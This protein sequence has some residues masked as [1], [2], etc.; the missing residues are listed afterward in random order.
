[1]DTRFGHPDDWGLSPERHSEIANELSDHLDCLQADEGSE[2]AQAAEEKLAEHKVRRRI[3]SAHIADQVTT[4][5]LRWPTPAEWREWMWLGFWI[6]LLVGGVLASHHLDITHASSRIP[7]GDLIADTNQLTELPAI[8]FIADTFVWLLAGISAAGLLTMLTVILIRARQLGLGVLMARAIQLNAVL[9]TFAIFLT[10]GFRT[11]Y[12]FPNFS[13]YCQVPIAFSLAGFCILCL[14]CACAFLLAGWRRFWAPAMAVLLLLLINCMTAPI[15]VDVFA[16]VVTQTDL[17]DAQLASLMEWESDRFDL[18]L[19]PHGAYRLKLHAPWFRTRNNQFAVW[20]SVPADQIPADFET[21]SLI[22]H[23]MISSPVNGTYSGLMWLL[24]PVPVLTMLG[25]LP[26]LRFTQ[27]L[28]V[29][30]R[31]A[32][33][34][35]AASSLLYLIGPFCYALALARISFPGSPAV[36]LQLLGKVGFPLANWPFTG[37]LPA[38]ER[39]MHG[40]LVDNHSAM[41][42]AM[43]IAVLLPWLLVGLHRNSS[44]QHQHDTQKLETAT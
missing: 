3:S 10:Q 27:G 1:M 12:S 25:V 28:S 24:L 13:A 18:A 22:V 21:R 35:L 31:I 8:R 14:I 9:V 42:S 4:T 19:I 23:S 29:F 38:M 33:P 11:Y 34:A 16:D 40:G 32:I 43:E 37:P 41:L 2:A 36:W 44:Q 5:L 7:N 39:L 30:G 26:L 15:R 20:G 6:V 17:D